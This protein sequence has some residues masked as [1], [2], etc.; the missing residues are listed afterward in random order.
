MPTYLV[1]D[2]ISSMKRAKEVVQQVNNTNRQ[3]LILKII[4]GIQFLTLFAGS[5]IGGWG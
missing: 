1:T 4:E 3:E 5:G 2:A